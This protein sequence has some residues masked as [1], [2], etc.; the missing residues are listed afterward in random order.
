MT[1]PVITSG[2]VIALLLNFFLQ[3]WKK[4]GDSEEMSEAKENVD[5]SNSGEIVPSSQG[6]CVQNKTIFIPN[7]YKKLILKI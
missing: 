4:F 3:V 2:T 5:S 7:Y 6:T 1:V